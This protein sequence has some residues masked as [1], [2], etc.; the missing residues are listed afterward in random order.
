VEYG[1]PIV[2]K[3]PYFSRMFKNAGTERVETEL[4]LLVQP[5]IVDGAAV[6]RR[7]ATGGDSATPPASAIRVPEAGRV[8]R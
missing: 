1:V 7:P 8:R 5:E 6:G 4:V 3:I 2:D